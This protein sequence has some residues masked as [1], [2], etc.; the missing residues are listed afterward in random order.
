MS[1]EE[2]RKTIATNIEALNYAVRNI[3]EEQLRMHLCW[4]IIRST[5]P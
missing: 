5:S 2:F 3:P 1:L 4:G